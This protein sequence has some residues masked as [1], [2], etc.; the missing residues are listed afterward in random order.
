MPD[1]SLLPYLSKF[2]LFL[3]DLSGPILWKQVHSALLIQ[4]SNYKPLKHPI[5]KPATGFEYVY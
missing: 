5:Q 3:K 2:Q 4:G 1:E